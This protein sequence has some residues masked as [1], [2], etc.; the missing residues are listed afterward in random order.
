L[1][2]KRNLGLGT[3]KISLTFLLY[4]TKFL[5]FYNLFSEHNMPQSNA[6]VVMMKIKKGNNFVP[7]EDK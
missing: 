6:N 4:H 5:N 3:K 7:K 2:D 1:V